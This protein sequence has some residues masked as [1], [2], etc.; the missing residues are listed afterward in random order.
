VKKNERRK[1]AIRKS[2]QKKTFISIVCSVIVLAFLVPFIL[3]AIQQSGARVFSDGF[4][5]ITLRRNGTFTAQLFHEAIDNGTYTE[6]S[7]GSEAVVAFAYNGL[8][9][10]GSISGNVLT[11]PPEWEDTHGHGEST[12]FT[13]R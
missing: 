4:Q 10:A 9:A 6:A 2:K 5:T 13:L 1:K 3:S 8:V 12:G 7:H 11:V